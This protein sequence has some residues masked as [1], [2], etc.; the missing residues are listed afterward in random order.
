VQ[1]GAVGAPVIT[2]DG[3]FKVFG[4]AHT[5]SPLASSTTDAAAPHMPLVPTASRTL[6]QPAPSGCPHEHGLHVNVPV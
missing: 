6:L 5:C 3:L 4:A 1:V 2:I